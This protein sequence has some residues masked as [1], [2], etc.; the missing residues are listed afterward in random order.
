MATVNA[1]AKTGFWTAIGV[2]AG[3]FVWNIVASRIP[4]LK[5][6]SG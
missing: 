2:L 6:F 3:L 1:N 5:Q 4:T